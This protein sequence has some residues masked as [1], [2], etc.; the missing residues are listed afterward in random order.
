[1]NTTP[2]INTHRLDF[3]VLFGCQAK[4]A[5]DH[6]RTPSRRYYRLH[7]IVTAR[8]P[9]G[10]QTVV[11]VR[12]GITFFCGNSEVLGVGHADLI[13]IDMHCEYALK[14]A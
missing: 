9:V 13:A 4:L 10:V 2:A 8:E 7:N 3:G 1:M 6:W 12:P 5:A 14:S 11:H